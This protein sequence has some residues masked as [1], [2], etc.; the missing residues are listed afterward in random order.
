MSNPAKIYTLKDLAN[1]GIKI[2]VGDS[3][4]PI[5]KYSL[6]I[7]DNLGKSPDYGPAYENSV[8]ANIV[9]QETNA[10]AVA[11]KVQLGEADAGVVYQ[12]D[13]TPA[14][15]N[16]VIAIDIP[17][18]FNVIAEYPIAVTKHAAHANDG[19]AFVHYI[20]SSDGQAVL[21]KYH[22]ITVSK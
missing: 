18:N 16:K 8:K 22:F 1:K 17:V 21:A 3:S 10:E 20:L 13:V 9:S 5:G 15:A 7:L 11:Q 6:Q 12:T 2:D 4:V 14:I 19:Q